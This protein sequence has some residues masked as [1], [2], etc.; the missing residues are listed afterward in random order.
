MAGKKIY[1]EK[2]TQISLTLTQTAVKWLET[3]KNQLTARSLSD[4]IE[5]MAREPNEA[6]DL[7]SDEQNQ[8]LK[9]LNSEDT[10]AF[11]ENLPNPLSSMQELLAAVA[12][13]Q[14]CTQ[15]RTP[16]LLKGQLGDTFFEPLP[17][18]E[19]QQWG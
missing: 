13:Y 7:P 12:L 2:K 8:T 9:F 6:L 11:L 17:E 5:R 10:K 3:R 14:Q 16:S 19:L 15:P 4:A 1:G 18:E